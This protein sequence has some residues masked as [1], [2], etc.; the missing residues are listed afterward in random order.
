M[1]NVKYAKKNTMNYNYPCKWNVHTGPAVVSFFF[2][3]QFHCVATIRNGKPNNQRFE[4]ADQFS[5]GCH[6]DG[7]NVKHIDIHYLTAVNIALLNRALNR[8]RPYRAVAFLLWPL[9]DKGGRIF[10]VI[11]S[12][13]TNQFLFVGFA[14]WDLESFVCHLFSFLVFWNKMKLIALVV[15]TL[16]VAGTFGEL[17]LF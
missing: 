9:S 2:F 4:N 12:K 3:F 15:L 16:F 1:Y 13:Q 8:F 6:L 10:S 14:Y 17:I 7:E 5:L 11:Y